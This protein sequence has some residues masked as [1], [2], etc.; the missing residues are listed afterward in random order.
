M[1]TP[2]REQFQPLPAPAKITT[3]HWPREVKPLV[4]IACVA[5]NHERFIAQAIRGFLMQETTFPVEIIVHDDASRDGTADIVREYETQHP[6]LVKSIVQVQN[7]WS[8]GVKNLW[9]IIGRAKGDFIALCEGDDYWIDP[10]KL[11]RQ[12]E[13]LKNNPSCAFCFHRVFLSNDQTGDM[14]PSNLGGPEEESQFTMD[15]L[16]ENFNFVP[17]ASVVLRRPT[18]AIM[19][20]WFKGCAY[21]DFPL[22]IWNLSRTGPRTCGRVE[23]RMAVYRQHAGGMYSG[24]SL[25]VNAKR[26]LHTYR[27]VG[28]NLDLKHRRA[29]NAGLARRYLR[30]CFGARE[31]GK[32]FVALHSALRAVC[33]APG[34]ERSKV[35]VVLS[36]PIQRQVRRIVSG[37]GRTFYR[38][39]RSNNAEAGAA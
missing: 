27:I 36:R 31:N 26:A 13:Y 5:Y 7:Q 22:H 4:T 6:S 9:T 34:G 1:T 24:Q 25:L 19:P 37:L 20:R 11:Q 29:F 8:R 10:L 38:K 21:G 17:T 28:E 32:L 12:V 16:L 15:D 14:Q 35:L 30:L 23:G 18:P 2:P 3:Q 39:D 33:V